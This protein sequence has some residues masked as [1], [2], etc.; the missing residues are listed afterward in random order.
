[1]TGLDRGEALRAPLTTVTVATDFSASADH[2]LM[3]VLRLRLA[4]RARILVLHVLPSDLPSTTA[5]VVAREAK[6]R[7]AALVERARNAASKF[8]REDVVVRPE[9]VVGSPHVEIVRK[10]RSAGSDLITLGHHGRR[11]IRDALL[12]STAERVLRRGELPVLVVRKSALKPY[13]RPLVAVDTNDTAPLVLRTALRIVAAPTVGVVHA[14]DSPFDGLV[15]PALD[16]STLQ[17]IRRDRRAR[18]SQEL[19]RLLE[20]FDDVDVTFERF[21]E[22]GSARVVVPAVARRFKADVVVAGTHARST[23]GSFLLGSTAS[24]LLHGL[25]CDVLITSQAPPAHPL[26]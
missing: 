1:M 15:Y 8:G 11:R 9:C 26:P 3:R 16:R 20:G 19:G 7:L 2:A 10:A 25:P 6:T 24:A 22:L 23:L 21:L 13:E 12:G 14:Y 17:A 18:A 4:R 5:K